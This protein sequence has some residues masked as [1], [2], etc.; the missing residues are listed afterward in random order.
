MLY[1]TTNLLHCQKIEW[2]VFVFL[3]KFEGR[4]HTLLKNL[5]ILF[6][7]Y[8][9]YITCSKVSC[10]TLS[11][12]YFCINCCSSCLFLMPKFVFDIF[13][14]HFFLCVKNTILVFMLLV[15]IVT[16]FSVFCFLFRWKVWTMGSLYWLQLWNKWSLWYFPFDIYLLLAREFWCNFDILRLLFR[17]GLYRL[18]C[19][20]LLYNESLRLLT[21]HCHSVIS[22]GF[23]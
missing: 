20:N 8:V 1:A 4:V 12:F 13:F 10:N 15:V 21:E 19:W 23:L 9:F 2:K 3:C 6:P 5:Y 18:A 7:I 22:Y 14:L 17:V 16:I 11:F